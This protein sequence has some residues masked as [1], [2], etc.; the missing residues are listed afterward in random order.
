[1]IHSRR[2]FLATGASAAL[3]LAFANRKAFASPL[4]LPLGIQLYSVRE[5][6]GVDLSDALGAIHAAGYTE[7]EAAALPK[8]S[9]R[10]IRAALDAA[11]LRCVSAH[12]PFAELAAKFDEMVAFDRELGVK[13]MICSSPGFCNPAPAG[14]AVRVRS[15]STTGSTTQNSST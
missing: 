10:D 13:F 14:A 1:M 5:Q 9:A 4:G 8:K 6:M 2:T 15:R 12:H 11:S 7:V 3:A